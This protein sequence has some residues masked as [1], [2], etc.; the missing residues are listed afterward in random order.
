M[1]LAP[2]QPGSATDDFPK[3]SWSSTPRPSVVTAAHP[4]STTTTDHSSFPS[5]SLSHQSYSSP[6]LQSFD[7]TT[8]D[9]VYPY[10]VRIET[11]EVIAPSYVL[12]SSNPFLPHASSWIS[13]PL[14]PEMFAHLAAA[15]MLGPTTGISSSVPSSSGAPPP[16]HRP[17][18][19]PLDTQ[20]ESQ[21]GH[22]RNASFASPSHP[23]QKPNHISSL[24]GIN[25][26]SHNGPPDGKRIARDGDIST[27]SR[28]GSTGKS[29]IKEC[30]ALSYPKTRQDPPFHQHTFRLPTCLLV[31]IVIPIAL[32]ADQMLACPQRY[33]CPHLPHPRRHPTSNLTHRFML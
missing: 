11:V 9:L 32:L 29:F 4:S 5:A 28:Q 10:T 19:S 6:W 24:S 12:Q 2:A 7:L 31:T 13:S 26:R 3:P 23:Y 15:G 16:R 14:D 18:L 17:S 21:Q 1:E 25:G 27:H 22:S 20:H 30:L 8:P 33:G